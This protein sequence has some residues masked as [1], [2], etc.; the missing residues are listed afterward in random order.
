MARWR[1]ARRNP[2]R[3]LLRGVLTSGVGIIAF[4]VGG[5]TFAYADIQNNITSLDVEDLV[6]GAIATSATQSASAEATYDDPKTGQPMNILVMG[7]DDRSGENAEIGGNDAGMRSDTTL[8]FHISADRSRIDA[9]SIPR[10]LL[11]PIPA[12]PLPDGS[13][14]W[15]QDDAMFNSAFSQ[16]S[17][18]S[19]TG[20]DEARQYG[21]ACTI[22]TV[23]QMTG[24][25]VDEFALVDFAG[26]QRMVDAVGGVDV[27]LAEPLQDDYTGLDLPAGQQTLDGVQAL[28]LARARHNIG[29]GSDINRIDRQQQL[30]TAMIDELMSKNLLT[31]SRELYQFL[32]AATQSLT[33]SPGLSQITSLVGLGMSLDNLSL[34]DVT[35]ATVPFVYEGARVRATAKA[36][37]VWAALAADQPLYTA[38]P[39]LAPAPTATQ[40]AP[41][42]DPA[43]SDPAPEGEVA[44][45]DGSGASD[46]AAPATSD[47]PQPT[48]D[49]TPKTITAT[50]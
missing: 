29:D 23:Q 45:S 10:D 15:A 34:S 22:L 6:N 43:A 9:V 20:S 25:T 47:A 38:L 3:S 46:P 7:T 1:H 13:S 11:T 28:Q 24:L 19:D 48:Q 31:N 37:D 21:A 44:T 8:L 16:G 35:F 36:D 2:S 40:E 39:E 26:F 42:G 33:T 17:S 32:S 49:A 18:Q 41:A 4:V 30:L 27:C 12:C 50:C 14:T 5:V